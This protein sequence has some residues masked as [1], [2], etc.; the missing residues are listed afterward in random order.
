MGVISTTAKL[1]AL[2][3]CIVGP[4][5]LHG[6][7]SF[8][9]FGV[10]TAMALSAISAL[11]LTPAPGPGHRPVRP[12]SIAAM[13]IGS[14]M[15]VVPAAALRMNPWEHLQAATLMFFMLAGLSWFVGECSRLRLLE[16]HASN[17]RGR[18]VAQQARTLRY[19]MYGMFGSIAIG[20]APAALHHATAGMNVWTVL[21][22]SV[23]LLAFTLMGVMLHW[24]ASRAIRREASFAKSVRQCMGIVDPRLLPDEPD[25]DVPDLGRVTI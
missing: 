4:M 12:T 20:L 14:G 17:I 1:L 6:R 7:V 24:Q 22:I 11:W 9:A 25:W 10:V 23:G 8:E 16:H 18:E 21:T 3:G 5:L 15:I 19:G 2:A 13:A